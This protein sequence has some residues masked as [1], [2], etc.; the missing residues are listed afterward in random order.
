MSKGLEPGMTLPDFTLPDET[1]TRHRLSTLQG[2]DV[3]VLH[4]SRGEHCP[5]ERMHHRELL[6]FHEWCDVGFTRLV[7]I[8]PNTLHDTYKMK[9][10]TG[11][12][13]TFLADEDLEVRTALEID[14]YDP[15]G[16]A[17]D[18]P[19]GGAQADQ[20]GLRPDGTRGPC[21][22]RGRCHRLAKALDE[23][24]PDRAPG[25]SRAH[26]AAC[27]RVPGLPLV[28]EPGLPLVVEPGHVRAT[29]PGSRNHAKG[30]ARPLARWA[31]AQ[32]RVAWKAVAR[33]PRWR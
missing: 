14:E 9:I 6:R 22:V 28:V 27:G 5:R 29:T 25:V 1:G 7:S 16:S 26:G 24:V 17:V 2:T 8:L 10:A 13:W 11:A 18:R 23:P 12:H 31:S 3:L 21:G 32:C 30:A 19:A 4:L 33:A 15:A 20:G